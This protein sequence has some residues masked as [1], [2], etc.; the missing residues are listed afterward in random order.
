MILLV[1][2]FLI[3]MLKSFPQVGIN[4]DGAQPDPSA[5]LDAK[6]S[7]KGL[8]I[9]RMTRA[10]RDALA[11]PANGLLVI[12]TDCGA[13]GTMNIFLNGSWKVF[14][15]SPCSPASPV[16]GSHTPSQTQI[17]WN[18]SAIAGATGYRW[19]T[20]GNYETAI[21]M[22][23]AT[24][25]TE[26]G[27][28]C[29]NTYARY[30]WACNDCGHSAPAS[31]SQTTSSC[32]FTC[33][34]SFTDSRDGRV[35]STVLIGTQC[36]MAQN[37]NTGTRINGNIPQSNNGIIE[38][39]CYSNI[40]SNCDIYG[41]IYQWNE[42]MNYTASSNSNPSGRQGICPSGWHAPSDAEWCQLEQFLDGSIT[43]SSTAYR[44][45][46]AG[47]LLKE[48]GTAHWQNPNTGATNGSGF[49]ALPGGY[50]E[51]DGSYGSLTTFGY[52]HTSTES[53]ST[54]DWYRGLYYGTIQIGRYDDNKSYGYSVRCVKD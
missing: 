38:K 6:S 52:F 45:T 22:G 50:S 34:Q 41:G 20:S 14:D 44:G 32:P 21:D 23:T 26:T 15:L 53:T 35:Y 4:N 9:P 30:V 8:L 16:A 36:W 13:D 33:G 10:Q 43:C 40:E 19:S 42:W 51:L 39:Y 29:N 37:L 49:T 18:W 12:C 24:T 28:A 7:S 27:L 46:V 17:I 31:L 1:I 54:R 11:A 2:A 5:I 47:G 25:Y 48:T 3:P